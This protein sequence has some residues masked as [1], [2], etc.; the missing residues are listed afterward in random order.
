MRN[1]GERT[2]YPDLDNNLFA[3]AT[4]ESGDMHLL[5]GR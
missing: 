4:M 5:V 3:S 1:E 2:N